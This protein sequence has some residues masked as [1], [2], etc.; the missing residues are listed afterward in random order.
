MSV[1]RVAKRTNG[2]D[3]VWCVWSEMDRGKQKI[4]R[5]TFPPIVLKKD[6]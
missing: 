1:E 5:D 4:Q 3:G 6:E 2:E